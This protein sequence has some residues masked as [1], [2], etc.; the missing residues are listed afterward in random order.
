M[1]RMNLGFG[2]VKV[3]VLSINQVENAHYMWLSVFTTNETQPKDSA[4][5][6]SV[7]LLRR[8]KKP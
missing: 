3:G 4:G 7:I 2:C 8:T 1:Y 6:N 5:A